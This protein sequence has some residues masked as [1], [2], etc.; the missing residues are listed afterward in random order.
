MKHRKK[1]FA[2]LLS[3]AL[4]YGGLYHNQALRSLFTTV[5]KAVSSATANGGNGTSSLGG[6]FGLNGGSTS[7]EPVPPVTRDSGVIH[8]ASFNIQVFG[9]TKLE[10]PAVMNV[11]C[12]VV[13]RFDLVAIQEVRSVR[14]DILP[15][16]VQMI[17]STGRHYDFVIGPR[18]GRTNSKEQYAF[19]FDTASIEVDRR[20]LYA[21]GDPYDRLQRPP[22]VA[23][24]RVRGPDPNEAFT[25][26]LADIHTEPD[27]TVREL[28]AC[29][30]VFK[31]V[32]N[33]GSDEDDVI[34]LGDMNVDDKHLGDLG[35][36]P[37]IGW[38]ISN[39]FTNTRQSKQYDNMV[40]NRQA[41]VEYTGRSG[42]FDL[43]REFNLTLDQALE[44]SDHFPIWAEFSIYEGGQPGR[45][46]NRPSGDPR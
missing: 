22:F 3:A 43:V 21:V 30:D 15:R 38:V 23:H 7:N 14:D 35:K 1:I 17:N 25:F 16:F 13:R 34:L 8:L 9:E 29:A 39:H 10:K 2:G 41:T 18:M 26:S 32:R 27:D 24:F 40:F 44:I 4:G 42:V 11:L 19:I 6:L 20:T 37:G 33:D 36:L 5:T 28:N 46:A 12:E 45:L 31:A